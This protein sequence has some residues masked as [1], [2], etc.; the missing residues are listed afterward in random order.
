MPEY[1]LSMSLQPY[2]LLKTQ[3]Q[4]L[5][6]PKSRERFDAYLTALTGDADDLLIPISS[7][8]PMSKEHV[9][10]VVARLID[11]NAEQILVNTLN[12]FNSTALSLSG[13]YKVGLVV[14][15]DLKGGWTCRETIEFNRL[16]TTSEE[17]K[18]KW[19]T[20]LWWSADQCTPEAI[21]C[22]IIDQTC[23]S[24]AILQVGPPKTLK[25]LV[26]L[27]AQAQT[28]CGA[29]PDYKVYSWMAQFESLMSSQEVPIL[30]SAFYGDLSAEKLGY[31]PL[32]FPSHAGKLVALNQIARNA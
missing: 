4:L 18:R 28:A 25:D 1:K 16:M 20:V 32:G 19:I 5:E 10:G 30:I 6:L 31:S 2:E 8:N 24:L 29:R 21:R 14:A 13:D 12:D 26:E 22:A 17:L 7:F 3:W 9:K 23:K 27:E 15:D 11:F